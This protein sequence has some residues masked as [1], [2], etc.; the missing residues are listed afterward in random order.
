M[1]TKVAVTVYA[2]GLVFQQVFGIKKIWG[3]DFFW[4]AAIGLVVLT[5]LYT[6]IGGI[7]SVLYTAILQ[8]PILLLGSLIIYVIMFK[9]LQ[10]YV[11]NR[12]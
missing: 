7:K 3:V 12:T 9:K 8:T 6:I 5:A 4:I 11:C 1:L 2:D 10:N